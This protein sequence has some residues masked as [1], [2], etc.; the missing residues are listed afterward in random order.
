MGA[1]IENNHLLAALFERMQ[2]QG[3]VEVIK[4]KVKEIKPAKEERQRPII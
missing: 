1:S 2:Q 3:K 4:Q